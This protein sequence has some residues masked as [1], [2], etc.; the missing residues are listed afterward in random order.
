MA[1]LIRHAKMPMACALALFAVQ[2]L[3]E[4]PDIDSSGWATD[5]KKYGMSA[6]DYI[7]AESHAG[8]TDFIKRVGLNTFYHFPGLASAEDTFVVSPN[9][10]TIYSVATVNASKGFTLKLPDVG[11]RFLSVQVITEDHTTPF[12][13]YGGG[14]HTFKA[15]DLE[16]DYITVAIRTGTD[17]SAE[18]IAYVTKDL[19]P[20]YAIEGAASEDTLARPDVETMKK[21]R[22]ALLAE[23]S[24]LDDTFDTMKRRTEDI[25]DWERFTY[26]SAGALGL[27]ADEDAMYKPYALTGAKGGQCYVATYPKVPAKAFF[28][29]TVYGPEKY[30]MSNED[31]IVTSNRGISLNDDGSFTV[32]FGDETCRKLAP[33]F[34]YTPKDGWSFLMRAYRP[35]VEAFKAY[36]MPDLKKVD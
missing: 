34:A 21:V 25:D 15:E 29:I 4:I 14:T 24:K 12:H 9:N 2:A 31:N 6:R 26:V 30:L 36:R 7:H 28:S 3:A 20:Q 18:D 5:P 33:N 27:S 11:D 16:T 19:Q 35:D 23:Y 1:V 8:M 22:G 13:L 32:A 10:D 17:G